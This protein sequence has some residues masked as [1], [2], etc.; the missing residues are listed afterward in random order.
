MILILFQRWLSVCVRI[1]SPLWWGNGAV[2]SVEEPTA[3]LP[4]GTVS[5]SDGV[6]WAAVTMCLWLSTDTPSQAWQGSEG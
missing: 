4:L 2:R 1:Q 5:W 6:Q 3:C